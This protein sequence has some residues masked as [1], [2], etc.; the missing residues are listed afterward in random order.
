MCP[1]RWNQSP[2]G[3]RRKFPEMWNYI[4][5]LSAP[6]TSPPY[7]WVYFSRREPRRHEFL[8]PW[9]GSNF[10]GLHL[11]DSKTLAF[12]FSWLLL[13][14]GR[15]E[16]VLRLPSSRTATLVLA[17]ISKTANWFNLENCVAFRRLN[18]FCA[19]NTSGRKNNYIIVTRDVSKWRF[20]NSI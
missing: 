13:V 9:R 15:G 7:N 4:V 3:T 8:T 2:L 17:M 10:K 6:G 5:Y 16:V 1:G 11:L 12:R 14:E 20:E 19:T 18:F